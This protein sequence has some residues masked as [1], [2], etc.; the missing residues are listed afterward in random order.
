MNKIA[1]SVN[2]VGFEKK[3]LRKKSGQKPAKIT[4]KESK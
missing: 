4:E 2:V 3:G 1:E